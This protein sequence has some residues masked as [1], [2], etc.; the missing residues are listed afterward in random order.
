MSSLKKGADKNKKSKNVIV[1]KNTIFEI[2]KKIDWSKILTK[3]NITYFVLVVLDIVLVIYM[4]R[5]NVVNYVVILDQEIFVSKTKYLLFGRNYI[6]LIIMTFIYIYTCLIAK[7][8]LKKKITRKFL[9]CLLVGIFIFNIL[10][11]FIFTRKV[12]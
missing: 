12:Y 10:L 2:L 8:F 3:V 9:G 7:F 11:F 5:Q 4:A 6:N 1:R